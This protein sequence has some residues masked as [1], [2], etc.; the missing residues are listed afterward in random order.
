VD[1]LTAFSEHRKSEK[2]VENEEGE[3]DDEDEQDTIIE[4]DMILL[5]KR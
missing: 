2:V 1:D 3:E 4:A 5:M